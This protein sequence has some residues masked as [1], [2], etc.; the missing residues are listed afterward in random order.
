MEVIVSGAVNYIVRVTTTLAGTATVYLIEG[1]FPFPVGKL[2]VVTSFTNTLFN[3]IYTVTPDKKL[4]YNTD[5]NTQIINALIAQQQVVIRDSSTSLRYHATLS[6][7]IR[8]SVI[9]TV[10]TIEIIAGSTSNIEDFPQFIDDC[11]IGDY[12]L[13]Y[14]SNQDPTITIRKSICSNAVLARFFRDKLW[15]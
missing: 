13:L 15:R 7:T 9:Y 12:L 5:I 2:V 1:S 3:G 11:Q 6:S 10:A 8:N 14:L 4:L